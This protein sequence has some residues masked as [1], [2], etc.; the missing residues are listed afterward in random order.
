METF[1]SA[2]FILQPFLERLLSPEAARRPCLV[3]RTAQY[4]ARTQGRKPSKQGPMLDFLFRAL[5]AD[6]Q[7]GAALFDA[8]T[9]KAREKHWYVEGMVP[10]TI[11]GRFAVVATLTALVLLRLEQDDNAASVAVTER[12]VE[13]METEHRELGLGD[14]SLGRTVRSLV[15]SLARRTEMWRL[16]IVDQRQW[17]EAA[18]KSLYRNGVPDEVL[19]HVSDALLAFWNKLRIV[20][21]EPLEEG[22]LQ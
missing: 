10:D 11:D 12:F 6:P 4:A 20:D 22:K 3:E 9:A 14:P 21:I 17:S 7:R 19:L 8:I 1:N 18:R 16:A 15:G 5:T 13:V 2:S